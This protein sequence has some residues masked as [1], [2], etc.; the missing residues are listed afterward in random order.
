MFKLW[1]AL[2]KIIFWVV[3]LPIQIIN[4]FVSG[5]SKK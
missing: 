4:A 3:I 1:W 5:F 2:I